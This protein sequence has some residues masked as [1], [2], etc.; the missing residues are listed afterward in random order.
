MRCAREAFRD[1]PRAALPLVLAVLL[2]LTGPVATAAEDKSS[3]A[4]D[5]PTT[6]DRIHGFF[7]MDQLESRFTRKGADALQVNG[8]GW[9]GGDYNRIWIK[10]E[11]TKVYDGSWEAVDVQLLYGR[12]IAPFWD[13]QAGVRYSQPSSDGPARASAVF[14]VQGLAPQWFDV[15]A[16][17]FISNRGEVSARLEL[18][19]DF[20]LTQRL[21]LQ[22]RLETNIA[23]Q[24]V[25]ELGIGEGVNDLE[26][27]ARLRYEI[28]REFA[29]YV[30]IAW[31]S[32]F[33]QA[34]DLARAQG[35]AVQQFSFVVGVRF[36]F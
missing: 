4:A 21:I 35:N 16:A 30:G 22:P 27:G 24:E 12:L 17:A 23:I 15:E 20:L 8:Y 31:T 2:L 11:G 5:A 25:K 9:V 3:T 34:A 19:Y 28:R 7:L 36:W 1:G 18:E 26:L 14:G 6:D 10:P 29:P 13:L 32:K 33:G